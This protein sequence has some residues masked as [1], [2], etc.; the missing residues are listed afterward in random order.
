VFPDRIIVDDSL[1]RTGDG[2]AFDIRLNWYRALPLS[3]V[4]GLE[5][6][7]DQTLVGPNS[8][9]ISLNGRTRALGDLE[10]LTNEWWYVTDPATVEVRSEGVARGPHELDVALSMRIP[11]LVHDGHAIVVR[12]QCRK[13]MTL[14]MAE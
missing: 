11:Y 7:F 4:D 1:R 3:C 5:V 14:G 6:T 9:T 13:A 10:D 2:F 8:V 12:E